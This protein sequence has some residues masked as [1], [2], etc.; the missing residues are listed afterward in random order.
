M[1][2][3]ATL[4]DLFVVLTCVRE[5]L[6]PARAMKITRFFA[7][8]MFSETLHRQASRS[9]FKTHARPRARSQLRNRA[10]GFKNR[11]SFLGER[12]FVPRTCESR[13]GICFF[14]VGVE[15]VCSP[16]RRHLVKIL[17]KCRRQNFDQMSTRRCAIFS[18]T[19]ESGRFG[20]ASLLF[21]SL[22]DLLFCFW[23]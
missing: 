21:S 16:V 2:I 20:T 18:R 14:V 6:T 13:F 5:T 9:V 4:G 19:R 23:R 10:L 8:N 12:N 22:L 11:I 3:A 1:S 17:T 7:R 15:H